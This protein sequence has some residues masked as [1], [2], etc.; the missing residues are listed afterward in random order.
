M[1]TGTDRIAASDFGTGE[2]QLLAFSDDLDEVQIIDLA[3]GIFQNEFDTHYG[4]LAPEQTVV[5]RAY[6]DD[7]DDRVLSE[8]E[9]RY[10]VMFEPN[11][12]FIRRIEVVV[13]PCVYDTSDFDPVP[14]IPML[15]SGA[16]SARIPHDLS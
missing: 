3:S 11:M 12:D 9:P 8:I 15:K 10:I 4:L 6:T 16:V 2:P 5:V 7:S 1:L 13:T 14:G